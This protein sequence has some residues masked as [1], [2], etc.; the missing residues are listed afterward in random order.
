MRNKKHH[1]RELSENVR[2]SLGHIPDEFVDYFTRRFPNLLLHTYQALEL[3]AHE[4][5]FK[6]YYPD[7]VIQR[8]N[9]FLVNFCAMRNNNH[10]D[11]QIVV[12]DTII[13]DQHPPVVLIPA[14]VSSS[15]VP[16]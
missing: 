15:I 9:N 10:G 5:V 8:A 1:Y 6:N 13:T 2:L 12:V 14:I 16:E 7:E 3:C 4:P 11:Q